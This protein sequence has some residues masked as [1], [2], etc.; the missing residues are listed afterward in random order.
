M[1]YF[2]FK[3][4]RKKTDRPLEEISYLLNDFLI[5]LKALKYGPIEILNEDQLK[6]ENI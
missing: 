6:K 2:V 4:P 3:T 5:E 1:K